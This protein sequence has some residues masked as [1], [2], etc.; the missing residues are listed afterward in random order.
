M[1]EFTDTPIGDF[2]QR[3]VSAAF[4]TI[5]EHKRGALVV[6]ANHEGV[7]AQVAAKIGDTWQFAAGGG[8]TW[9]GKLEGSVCIVGAW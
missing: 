5:P 3:Q 2:L 4:A 7:K 1:S 9:Q 6:V 8:V